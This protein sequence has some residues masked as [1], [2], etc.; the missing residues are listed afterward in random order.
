M[1]YKIIFS[2]ITPYNDVVFYDKLSL[3]PFIEYFVL[4]SLLDCRFHT[5]F[6]D[7]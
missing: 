3:T 4:Y 2:Q 1:S 6:N 5:V 7:G